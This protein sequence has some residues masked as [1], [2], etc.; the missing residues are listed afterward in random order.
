MANRTEHHKK[1]MIQALRETL[2]VVTPALKISGVKRTQYY[3]WLKDDPE[4]KR[5]VD[6]IKDEAL[7]FAESQLM[8]NIKGEK[9]VND[10]GAEYY[11]NKPSDTALIFYLKTQGK[12]RGYIERVEN[13]N[14]NRTIEVKVGD[15]PMPEDIPDSI[16][17][18]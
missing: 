16:D 18:D 15:E 4:F 11:I 14:T 8:K 3:N 6:S 12:G 10:S 13:I 9:G 7:D 5:D 2:S 17:D 1:A